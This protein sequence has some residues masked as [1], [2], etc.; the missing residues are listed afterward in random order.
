MKG[1]YVGQKPLNVLSCAVRG[2]PGRSAYEL[3]C[4]GGYAGTNEAFCTLLGS[5]DQTLSRLLSDVDRINGLLDQMDDRCVELEDAVQAL[6]LRLL[7]LE[8]MVP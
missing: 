4:D 5:L 7:Q 6:N 3:A 2:R 8:E 1:V